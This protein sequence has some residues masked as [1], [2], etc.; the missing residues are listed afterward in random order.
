MISSRSVPS[1]SALSTLSRISLRASRGWKRKVLAKTGCFA[2]PHH[3]RLDQR[4]YLESDGAA[5]FNDAKT[6]PAQHILELDDVAIHVGDVEQ[7]AMAACEAG[8]GLRPIR[9]LR[10]GAA[11]RRSRRQSPAAG[12]K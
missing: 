7:T 3:A 11:P 10:A 8:Q 2:V 4:P 12:R 5:A 1:A 6:R 9:L